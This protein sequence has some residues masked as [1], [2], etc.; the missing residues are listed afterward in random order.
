[1]KGLVI[2]FLT[3]AIASLAC[4]QVPDSPVGTPAAIETATPGF[5]PDE[6]YE[7][8][9]TKVATVSPSPETC[10]KVIAIQS[11]H[12]RAGASE[13]DIVLAWLKHGDVVHVVDRSDSD[14]WFINFEGV[15]GY[16]RS[17]Y[18]QESECD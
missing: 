2:L 1:M 8:T 12:L 16:A 18:L 11:L 6:V 17:M 14:W 5:T 3:L 7:P 13:N 10:A 9:L 4:M 15:S